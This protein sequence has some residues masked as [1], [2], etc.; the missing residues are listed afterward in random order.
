MKQLIFGLIASVALVMGVT[1]TAKADEHCGPW[2]CKVPA[3]NV[4][5]SRAYAP[6]A[7]PVT[8]YQVTQPV[9]AGRRFTVVNNNRGGL[10]GRGGLCGNGG[11]FRNLGNRR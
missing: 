1:S 9:F 10:F 5:T 11:L 8:N 2:G 7:Y 4:V 6:A 3:S